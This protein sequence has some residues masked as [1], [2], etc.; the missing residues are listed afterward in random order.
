MASTSHRYEPRFGDLVT[1]DKIGPAYHGVV[2]DV[3]DVAGD[4]FLT[5]VLGNG[6]MIDCRP[7]EVEPIYLPNSTAVSSFAEVLRGPLLSVMIPV[8]L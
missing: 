8:D 5:V 4:V 1:V 6:L 2:M 7:H 3:T